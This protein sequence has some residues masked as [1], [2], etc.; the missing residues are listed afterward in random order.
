M[1]PYTFKKLILIRVLNY[2]LFFGIA[3]TRCTNARVGKQCVYHEVVDRTVVCGVRVS[4]KEHIG[5]IENI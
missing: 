3:H 1:G 2:L 5:M 4:V